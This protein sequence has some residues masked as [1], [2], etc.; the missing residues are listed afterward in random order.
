MPTLDWLTRSE[1]EQAA[2]RVSYRLLDIVPGVFDLLLE[3]K[4]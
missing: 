4:E 1:D 3:F 2:G